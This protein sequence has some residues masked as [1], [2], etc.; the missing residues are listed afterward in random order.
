MLQNRISFLQVTVLGLFPVERKMLH[1]C[2]AES[3]ILSSNSTEDL[4]ILILRG[5]FNVTL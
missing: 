3:L 4:L 1:H 2:L 5:H